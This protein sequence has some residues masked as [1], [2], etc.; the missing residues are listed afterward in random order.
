MISSV[1]KS[2]HTAA[3][4]RRGFTLIEVLVVLAITAIITTLLVTPMVQSFNITRRAQATVLSQESGRQALEQ[5]T[6]E[7]QSAVFV[8]DN[9]GQAIDI[10]VKGRV[11][12]IPYARVDLVLPRMVMHCN[13]PN[14]PAGVP[15]DYDRGRLAWPAC[16]AQ[17][18]PPGGN[19]DVEARVLNPIEPDGMM[20]RYFVGLKDPS[21]PYNN[22]HEDR[23]ALATDVENTFVLYRAEFSPYDENLI[24]DSDGQSGLLRP[25]FFYNQNRAPNG[26]T[27]SEN[28][29]RVS[30][31]VGPASNLDLVSVQYDS[32]GD[33][34]S[35]FSSVRF[36]PNAVTNDVLTPT[37]T[38]R[39]EYGEPDSPPTVYRATAGQWAPDYEVR[40]FRQGATVVFFTRRDPDSGHVYIY[41]AG[42]NEPVFDITAWQQTRQIGPGSPEFMFDVDPNKGEVTFAFPSEALTQYGDDVFDPALINQAYN[43]SMQNQGAGVRSIT[44]NRFAGLKAD[45][46]G[47]RIVPGS[48]RVTGP[49][50]VVG[51]DYGKPVLYTRVA[52]LTDDP[53]P[54]QYRIDYGTGTIFF[55]SLP[56]PAM[57][58]RDISGGPA[59]RVEVRFDFQNNQGFDPDSGDVL[60]VDYT[61][62]NVMSVQVG[63]RLYDDRGKLSVLQLSS[64]VV[65]RNFHR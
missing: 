25:D 46:P 21:Q 59:A 38:G 47:A 10:P 62:K 14:H 41:R 45:I 19:D 18:Q 6:R 65:I 8:Y 29:R 48:E 31:I 22:V 2:Y 12:K 34:V 30:H 26:R 35:V 64:N 36:V 60:S 13:S 52:Y 23:R 49:N 53:G 9:T 56:S 37:D 15:R 5:L 17:H 63:Y 28:W 50:W 7:L 58:E 51:P 43:D 4:G 39:R 16:P 27:F 54:N 42:R 44:L 3:R 11:F 40:V 61:T 20:V 32:N 1:P 55:Y 57:P 24:D 33:P